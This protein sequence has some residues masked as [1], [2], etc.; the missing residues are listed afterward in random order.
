MASWVHLSG[1][2]RS[3]GR[4][5][6]A[7]DRPTTGVMTHEAQALHRHWHK[8]NHKNPKGHVLCSDP[9]IVEMWFKFGISIPG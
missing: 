6:R 5:W 3:V 9:Q 4:G 2:V 8:F 7:L 1:Y